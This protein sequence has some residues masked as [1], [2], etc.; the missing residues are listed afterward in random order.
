M[1]VMD[2]SRTL[3]EEYCIKCKWCYACI[4]DDNSICTE[5]DFQRCFEKEDWWK[6]ACTLVSLVVN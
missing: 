5:E 3:Y 2:K 4:D 6:V 1:W